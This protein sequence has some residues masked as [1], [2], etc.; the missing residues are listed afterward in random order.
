MITL[1]YLCGEGGS[2][3]RSAQEKGSNEVDDRGAELSFGRDYA[4]QKRR[5]EHCLS[6]DSSYVSA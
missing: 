6:L 4:K 5:V 3:L 2:K 1:P